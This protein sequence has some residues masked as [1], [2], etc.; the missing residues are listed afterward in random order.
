M[1]NLKGHDGRW[2]RKIL[3]AGLMSCLLLT[4]SP[5]CGGWSVEP[6]S[7]WPKVQTVK[8][9]TK[10]EVQLYKDR[11]PKG[12]RR[13]I[14]GRFVS[15]TDNSITLQLTQRTYTD[16][17]IHALQKSDVRKVLTH[18]SILE[19]WPGWAVLGISLGL[20]T[21]L[22][23]ISEGD[24]NKLHVLTLAK[25]VAVGTATPFFI[26]SRMGRIYEVP[27]EH[28]DLPRSS[29]PAAVKTEKPNDSK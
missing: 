13:T 14:K 21:W 4:S 10:T 22:L 6:L 19:R 17:K 12:S 23:N 7:D 18:R 24:A 1:K 8:P 28:R 29:G 11:I 3:A 20:G 27:P 16:E 9:D 5:G 2:S 26:G 25:G 15:A